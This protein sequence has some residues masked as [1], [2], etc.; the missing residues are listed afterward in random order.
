MCTGATSRICWVWGLALAHCW[1][2]CIRPLTSN[3]FLSSAPG[4]GTADRHKWVVSSWPGSAGGCRV[5]AGAKWSA[6]PGTVVLAVSVCDRNS[7]RESGD[8]RLC[9][10]S[11]RQEL[12]DVELGVPDPGRERSP[13]TSS[14]SQD[15]SRHVV[16]GA[17]THFALVWQDEYLDAGKRG[18]SAGGPPRI[19]RF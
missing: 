8:E 13:F 17:K 1:A 10:P 7:G 9:V 3:W 11:H 19:L 18:T 6:C 5:E 12:S 16:R 4:D 14:E 15:C 2:V